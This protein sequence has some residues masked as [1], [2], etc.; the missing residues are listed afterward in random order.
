MGPRSLLGSEQ[1]CVSGRGRWTAAETRN[2]RSASIGPE[3]MLS[4]PNPLL[5]FVSHGGSP[6]GPNFGPSGVAVINDDI[7]ISE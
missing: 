6:L 7:H 3:G 5:E 1:E 4:G 2:F